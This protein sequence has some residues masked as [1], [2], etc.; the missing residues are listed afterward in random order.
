MNCDVFFFNHRDAQFLQFNDYFFAEKRFNLKMFVFFI[1]NDWFE[2]II[3]YEFDVVYE[4]EITNIFWNDLLNNIFKICF[5]NISKSHNRYYIDFFEKCDEL[6]ARFEI[7]NNLKI[8]FELN[9]YLKN[10]I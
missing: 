6:N 1:L 7:N 5:M 2:Y 9:M 3:I 8:N 4:H 10:E